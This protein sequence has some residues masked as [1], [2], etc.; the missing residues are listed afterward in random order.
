M[1]R[2]GFLRFGLAGS[3][4]AA[5]GA[6]FNPLAR[7]LNLK[8]TDLKIFVVDAQTDENFV[9][10]KIYT[11]QGITDLGEGTLTGKAWM[12]EQAILEHRRYLLGRDR[13][14]IERYW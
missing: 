2:S 14:E 12:V 11:N 4:L 1:K 5:A 6:S 3:V 10:V 7:F 9:F 8:I 13:T